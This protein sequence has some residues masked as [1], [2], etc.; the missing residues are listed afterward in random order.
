MRP[1]AGLRAAVG[2]LIFPAVPALLAASCNQT[3]GMGQDPRRW[4]VWQWCAILGPLAGYG[5]L[6]GALAGLPDPEPFVRRRLGRRA[7][8]VAV[9]PWL[10]FVA[11]VALVFGWGWLAERLARSDPW[12]WSFWNWFGGPIGVFVLVAT[13]A[14]GWLPLA[15]LAL[16][17]A[18]RARRF[19]QSLR[20]GLATTLA[21]VG[22]LVGAFWAATEAWRPYFFD[23][24]VARVLLVAA[25]GMALVSFGGCASPET[26]GDVRRRE[27]FDA[28][29]LAWVVGL[30]LL[31]RWWSRPR[32]PRG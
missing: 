20:D 24:R 19:W 17:R 2:W 14:L 4:S 9:G 25:A 11:F 22:S 18:W 21:F 12:T 15:I 31:W 16:R 28:L 3:L 26:V 7:L 27:L 23:P 13:I 8:W 10:G 30:A 1:G 6:A 5:F 29:L 32:G